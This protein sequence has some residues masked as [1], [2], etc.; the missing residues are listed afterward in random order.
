VAIICKKTVAKKT[1]MCY[2]V[3]VNI[4]LIIKPS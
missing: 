2:T 3:N 1:A 4:V